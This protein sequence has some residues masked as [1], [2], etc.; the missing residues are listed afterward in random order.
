MATA[1]VT[2]IDVHELNSS[3]PTVEQ[4][5]WYIRDQ[6]LLARYVANSQASPRAERHLDPEEFEGLAWLLEA[7]AEHV[8]AVS[9]ALDVET[10]GRPCPPVARPK[11]GRA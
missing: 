3:I 8:S 10:Y 9:A 2:P 6:V 4:R 7:V 5:L 1:P 11:A